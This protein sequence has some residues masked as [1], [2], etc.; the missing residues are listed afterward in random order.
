MKSITKNI[1]R[2]AFLLAM[3]LLLPVVVSCSSE[4]TSENPSDSSEAVS[5][6]NSESSTESGD[7]GSVNIADLNGNLKNSVA[8]SA[9]D[10]AALD[11]NVIM[12]QLNSL[13][14]PIMN[15]SAGSVTPYLNALKG[16]GVYFSNFFNQASDR[17]DTE[18]SVLNS[19][20]TPYNVDITAK[21]GVKF[22]T[23]ANVL[24]KAGYT[25]SAFAGKDDTYLASK[26]MFTKY[27]FDTVSVKS[28]SDSEIY[29]EALN[30]IKGGSGKGFYFISNIDSCYPYVSSSKVEAI[31]GAA[32][33]AD[34]ANASAVADVALKNFVQGLKDA[35]VYDKS[36]IVIYGTS[37]LFD[38]TYEEIE[39]ECGSFLANGMDTASA[40]NVPMFILGLDKS[41]NTVLSSVYDIYPTVVSL[42]GASDDGILVLGENL[43]AEADRSGK[44]FP[45]QDTLCRGSYI[46]DKVVYTRFSKTSAKCVDRVTGEEYK[47]A[48]YR[49]GDDLAK[50]LANESEYVLSSNYFNNLE[51]NGEEGTLKKMYESLPSS[52]RVTLLKENGIAGEAPKAKTALMSYHTQ[53][54]YAY[55]LVS[56]LFGV[57]N[58]GR[59]IV[60]EEGQKEGTYISPAINAGTFEVLYAGW[61]I[62]YN[63]GSAEIYVSVSDENGVASQWL[64]IAKV[65]AN[66]LN[67]TP[68]EDDTVKVDSSRV[69]MKKA[70]STGKV[71][72]KIK[73]F[74]AE[75]GASPYLEYFSLTTDGLKVF[76]SNDADDVE[77][78]KEELKVEHVQAVDAQQSGAAAVACLVSSSTGKKPDIA[79]V[80]AAIYDQAG[81]SYNNLNAICEYVHSLGIDAFI[82]ILDYEG[83]A[84][85]F[86]KKQQVLCYFDDTKSFSIIYGFE[87]EKQDIVYYVYDILTGKDSKIPS[88]EYAEKWDGVAV[89]MNT[90]VENIIPRTTLGENVFGEDPN[91]STIMEISQDRPGSV[92]EK[93]YITIH[94]TGNYP[95]GAWAVNHAVLKLNNNTGWT[96]WHFT[97]DSRSIYQHMPTDEKAWHASDGDTGPGNQNS[98]GIE[99]CVNGFPEGA[100]GE[101]ATSNYYGEKY[102]AWEKQFFITLENA[103]Q[104]V[105]QLLVEYELTPDCI[106]QHYDFARDKKNCPMQMRYSYETKTFVREGDMWKEFMTMVNI[107][108]QRLLE[109]GDTFDTINVD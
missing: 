31:N 9:K 30:A 63:G 89:I 47:V 92:Y 15:A 53:F 96:S 91:R 28:A 58:F 65:S 5:N 84:R 37:P 87:G 52:S 33:L 2:I 43:F 44:I 4:Q 21:D 86:E 49:S 14:T 109:T 11:K 82:D 26:S 42:T 64:Q 23:L 68:Y 56:G 93:K 24:K 32:S 73:L 20:M 7:S 19:L 55:D 12:I 107:R 94:N 25:A 18:Y 39:K 35:G 13:S 70:A 29:T 83:V 36:V 97:V 99:I 80:S 50:N 48:D 100:G 79:G 54:Y 10:K 66:V 108:Y 16:E 101:E 75:N 41:E 88:A 45:I 95:A 34:Y 60:L 61:D 72:V 27:G 17:L 104:L 85:V 46:S 74:A 22:N 102:E 6:G 76:D 8:S 106:R 67:C 90:Y 38:K 57:K 40:H 71:R 1:K 3:F 105:A 98:I 69:Y 78:M 103:S 77:L 81:N 51:K 62:K 59:N